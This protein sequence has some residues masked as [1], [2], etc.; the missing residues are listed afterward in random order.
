MHFVSVPVAVK[1]PSK[2][3]LFILHF[4]GLFGRGFGPFWQHTLIQMVYKYINTRSTLF[5]DM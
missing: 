1:I 5:I 3:V 4:D 2:R